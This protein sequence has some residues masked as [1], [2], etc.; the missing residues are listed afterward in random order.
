V[1][2]LDFGLDGKMAIVTGSG[3]GIGRILALGLAQAGAHIVV[4]DLAEKREVAEETARAVRG[5]GRRA[6]VSALDVTEVESIEAM[7]EKACSSF[8]RVDI[9]VNNAGTIVRKKALEVTEEDWDRVLDTNL[10]GAFFA[11]QVAAKAMVEQ[12]RGKIANIA[13]VNGIIGSP[14]RAAYTASK[15]GLINLTRTLAAEWAQH[16]INVNAIGP[17][18]LLTPFTQVLFD[19][20]DFMQGYFRRQPIQRIGRPEDLDGAAVYLASPASDLVTG[21]TLMVDGGWTAV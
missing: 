8:D 1:L 5:T 19:D 10:K 7:V 2:P 13:S 17:T 11:S 6:L 21:H 12:G 14:E 15:A 4:A 20:E 3:S 18:Y 9:L 16:G